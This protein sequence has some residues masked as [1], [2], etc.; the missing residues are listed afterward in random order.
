[1]WTYIIVIIIILLAVQLL[2]NTTHNNKKGENTT[3]CKEYPYTYK[4]LLS[5]A[6]MA[7]YKILET[8]CKDKDIKICPKVRME[9]F[10]NVTDK[11]QQ[12]K[13]RG[14][15]RSRHIDFILCDK[16]MNMIAG[17]ELDDESH[18]SDKT[19]QAD[20]F[21]NEVFKAIGKPLHRVKV[22][23]KYVDEIKNIIDTTSQAY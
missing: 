14:Y 15:I 17:I 22:G 21:K 10:L 4:N 8:E 13:Y 9:D 2:L 23:T 19:K 18:N 16:E 3:N 7:F 20:T 1:M 11:K 6:E 12:L 5:K